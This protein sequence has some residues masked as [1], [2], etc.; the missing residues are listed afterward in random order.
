MDS[1]LDS[2]G[3]RQVKKLQNQSHKLRTQRWLN[4]KRKTQINSNAII[5]VCLNFAISL[6][7]GS[8]K[9][10]KC[11][12]KITPKQFVLSKNVSHLF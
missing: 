7:E 9:T 5:F 1:S 4:G 12:L 10:S 6:V 11:Q 3:N 8:K 2:K